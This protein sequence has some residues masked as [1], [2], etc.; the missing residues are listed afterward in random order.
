MGTPANLVLVDKQGKSGIV[1]AQFF[2]SYGEGTPSARMA[3]SMAYSP[4]VH[5]LLFFAGQ[6]LYA[7]DVY[8]K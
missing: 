3:F 6:S 7:I 2:V 5:K 8:R 1:L 4:E